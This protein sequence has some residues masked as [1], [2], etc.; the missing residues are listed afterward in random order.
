[1]DIKPKKWVL[2]NRIGYNE[3]I[4]KTF[5]PEDY[6]L[7]NKRLYPQQRLIKDYIQINSPYRGLLLYHELGSGKSGA[8]IAAS[9]GYINKKKI[10]IL[11]PASLATNY[12]NE[13]L[14]FSSV[15]FNL[16]KDWTLVNLNKN[17]EKV[18][19]I[20]KNKYAIT[21]EI[22]KK[23]GLI[24]IPLYENDIPN[25]T[26][27]KS[28]VNE[29]DKPIINIITS[30][31]IRNRY[32]FISYNGLNNKMIE[33]LG[34]TP[35][36]NSF[37]IIDE[38]HNFSSRIVNGSRLTKKIY[39]KIMNARDCKVLL[40]SGTPI[41]NNPYEIATIINLIRGYMNIYKLSY[42]LTKDNI[43]LEDLIKQ[44]ENDNLMSIID[45][46]Y[47]EEEHKK[48]SIVLLPI[49]YKKIKDTIIQ[50]EE[51][52]NKNVIP[53]II[54]SLNKIEGLEIEIKYITSYYNA[55]PSIPKEFN[56]KFLDLTD[57][58]EPKIIN[59]DLFMRRILGT[60]SY[61]STTGSELF[62]TRNDDIIRYLDMTN[63]QLTN[64]A[65]VRTIERSMDAK[66]GGVM[67]DKSS[68]YRAFSRM[69]CNFSF[70]ENI[71][72]EYPLD[73]KKAMKQE[74]DEEED[75][76]KRI[77]RDRRILKPKITDMYETKL[78]IAINELIEGDYLKYENV[79]KLYSP[80][81]AAIY[82]DIETSPGSVLIY[83]QFRKVEG[84]GLLKEFLKKNG[85]I[86]I[87]LKKVEGEYKLID[88]NVFE[89]RYDNRR[90]VIFDQDKQKTE[91]LKK[92]FNGDLENISYEIK[93]HLP[94]DINQLYGKLVKIFCI[95]ASGAEGISL[96][97]VR[98]VLILEPYWNNIR[99][100]QV[101]GRAIRSGSHEKLPLK[102]RNVTVF[103]YIMRITKEQQEK[104]YT[105]ATLD[106]G[107]TTDEHILTIAEKK[108]SIINKFLL[109]LKASSFDCII[110]S[111][112]N[113]PLK[114]N[115]KCYSW[116]IGINKNDLSYTIDIKDDYKIITYKNRQIVKK[117]KGKVI[118]KNG[119]KYVELNGKIYNYY[120]YINAGILISEEI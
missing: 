64:Y 62:P 50:K 55:L 97:N 118:S 53:L 21:T 87:N 101:I 58:D 28:I 78:N 37:V 70:P 61:Y 60:I 33:G 107:K 35:F 84:L 4:L 69:V 26:I 94:E 93:K 7:K 111:E 104:N 47:F 57:E 14:K 85:Y 54:E 71:K 19:E 109:M 98:R 20:L 83:S 63:T 24:W 45:E 12:E 95:T 74:I 22:I 1:M 120:S 65:T 92:I 56:D 106:D 82:D 13:I 80:K 34:K 100:E 42:T 43:I 27:I 68:V 17:N 46:I 25:A 11:T 36:D 48:I 32:K 116:P 103:K 110:N 79:K 23:D 77:T 16:K 39:E 91:I 6:K 105:I 38:V 119:K 9:E 89:K 113:K 73:I 3:Q 76:L 52:E 114:N 44:L 72:R 5:K 67:S 29:I 40:L 90:F 41:I 10:Y 15:G 18:V 115:Y 102:D 88:E 75:I 86:E 81:Y 108:F 59:S 2:P 49:N 99:I 66:K 30:H 51:W 117:G 112:Q 31:I 8:S 96:K